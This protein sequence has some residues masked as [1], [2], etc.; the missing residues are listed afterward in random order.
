MFQITSNKGSFL[1]L[2]AS[3]ICVRNLKC[4]LMWLNS[5]RNVVVEQKGTYWA[6]HS[7]Y[8]QMGTELWKFTYKIWN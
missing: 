3:N 6:H 1:T 2:N 4:F 8:L 5:Q 7:E